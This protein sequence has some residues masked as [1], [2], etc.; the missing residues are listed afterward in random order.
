LDGWPALGTADELLILDEVQPAGK[1]SMA[2]NDFLNGA[3]DW[4]SA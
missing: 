3:R 1:K 4:E 2:G